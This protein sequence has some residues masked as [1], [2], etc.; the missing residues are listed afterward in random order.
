MAFGKKNHVKVDPTA[1]SFMLLGEPKIGKT[2]VM[3][4]ALEK[5]VGEDGY[6]FVELGRERGADSIEGINCINCPS[7]SEDYDEENNS[8][9]WSELVDDI[10]D[11]KSTEYA[12]L[13]VIAMDTYDQYISIAEDEALRL[14]NRENPDKRAKSLNA[15]WGG[16]GAGSKKAIELMFEQIDRLNAVGVKVWWIGHVR[17]KSVTDIATGD[18]YEV[19]S[20][21]QQQNYFNALK[22]NLHFLGLAYIDREIVKEKTGKKNVVTKKEEEKF[23]VKEESRKIKFRDDS[24]VVDCGTR[25]KDIVDTIDLDSDQLIAAMTDAIKAEQSKSGKSFEE[26]KKEQDKAEAERLKEIAKAEEKNKAKKEID[27]VI[28]KIN[29][30]LKENKADVAKIKPVLAACKECGVKTPSELTTL[31]DAL[32]VLEVIEA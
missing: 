5:L 7:W 21:D 8:V 20:S 29:D 15:S 6:Q 14:W 23:V 13:K 12:N 1:Y 4:E 30:Y 9:G 3:M 24:Y 2:T 26:T 27:A 19:L 32:K 16:F 28:T 10:C 18:T 11:N 22:K 17:N 25:F 31:E